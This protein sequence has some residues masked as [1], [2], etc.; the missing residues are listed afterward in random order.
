MP[1]QAGSLG[2]P[3]G[4]GWLTSP[5]RDFGR[6]QL[7][8]SGIAAAPAPEQFGIA[9]QTK[10]L[11]SFGEGEGLRLRPEPTVSRV[12]IIVASWLARDASPMALPQLSVEALTRN[13]KAP[14][15]RPGLLQFK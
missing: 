3:V 15:S 8:N 2:R 7:P 9:D 1:R 14:G 5:W 11:L 4:C 6:R 10:S 12:R 13:A